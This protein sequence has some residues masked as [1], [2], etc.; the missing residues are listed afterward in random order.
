MQWV[1]QQ[2]ERNEMATS[3]RQHL[4]EQNTKRVGQLEDLVNFRFDGLSGCTAQVVLLP[5]PSFSFN[6]YRV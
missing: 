3:V 2:N 4:A 1:S 6:S 5:G